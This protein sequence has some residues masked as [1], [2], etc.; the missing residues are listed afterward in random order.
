[1]W[2]QLALAAIVSIMPMVPAAYPLAE[3]Q[4]AVVSNISMTQVVEKQVVRFNWDK[5]ST[6]KKYRVRIFQGSTRIAKKF[7]DK[8]RAKFKETKFEDHQTYTVSV[9]AKGNVNYAANSWAT[10]TFIYFDADHDNDLIKDQDDY[11]DDN[12]GIPDTIDD[13]PYGV[14]GTVYNITIQDNTL[15][16]GT[17]TI[18]QNDTVTWVN[19]DEDRDHAVAANNNSWFSEPLQYNESY[20]HVFTEA[21]VYSY[22]DPTTVFNTDSMTGTITVNAQ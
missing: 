9:R 15:Q 2:R 10:Y 16:D 12:D 22:Y 19:R 18:L 6:A 7:V 8:N 11:D 20:S 14:S 21:G 4:H 3:N 17:I 13:D 1:M 5:V